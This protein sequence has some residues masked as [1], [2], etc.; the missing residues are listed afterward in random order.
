MRRRLSV[1]FLACL[2]EALLYL[3][4]SWQTLQI[5]VNFLSREFGV[6]CHCSQIWSFF[7]QSRFI[8]TINVV[9]VCQCF[10]TILFIF[11]SYICRFLNFGKLDKAV[12]GKSKT[13][14]NVIIWYCLLYKWY[15]QMN[16]LFKI[17]R[18]RYKPGNVINRRYGL[19][20]IT[21]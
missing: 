1:L 12:D 6:T 3:S 15:I 11:L 8:C 13:R 10:G 2:T 4:K 18:H 9:T 17:C 5:C 20:F 16:V 7:F 14:H 19:A 21:N